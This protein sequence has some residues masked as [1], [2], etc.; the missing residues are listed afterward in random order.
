MLQVKSEG[1]LLENSLFVDETLLFVLFKLA[2]EWVRITHIMKGICFTRSPSQNT[3]TE[4]VS[5]TKYLG[6]S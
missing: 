3:L 4:I 5:L 1:S 2:D 6:I